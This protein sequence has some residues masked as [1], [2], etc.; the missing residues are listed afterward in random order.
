LSPHIGGSTHEAQLA[1][2]D[3]VAQRFIAFMTNGHSTGA[4]NIPELALPYGGQSTH[5]IVNFHENKPG[6]LKA[7]NNIL[8]VYNVA[9][10]VLRTMEHI[11]YLVADVESEA[12]ET[13]KEQI[14]A[15]PTTIRTRILY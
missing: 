6:V 10:Q 5:R 1:I 4:V 3:E 11:G 14:D 12:S 15:L 7:I 8:S 13:I 9:S 2:A